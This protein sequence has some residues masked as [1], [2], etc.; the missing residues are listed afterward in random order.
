MLFQVVLLLQLAAGSVLRATAAQPALQQAQLR[1]TTLPAAAMQRM[2][3]R[4]LAV[5]AAAAA[6]HA[7]ECWLCQAGCQWM[8]AWA[9][10]WQQLVLGLQGSSSSRR[11]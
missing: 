8:M 9:S 3:L 11:C 7:A 2:Q 5:T 1:L 4:Y 10:A 6:R